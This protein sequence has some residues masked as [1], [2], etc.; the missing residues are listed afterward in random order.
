M[1]SRNNR[2]EGAAATGGPLLQGHCGWADLQKSRIGTLL[3]RVP[4][5]PQ[6]PVARR[7]ATYRGGVRAYGGDS[8][9]PPGIFLLFSML[10]E[11]FSFAK[12]Y[13]SIN[14]RLGL[15]LSGSTHF[16]RVS[17]L[18]RTLTG[19]RCRFLSSMKNLQL[20]FG[21]FLYCFSLK[22]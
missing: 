14:F 10:K 3:R 1:G 5:P 19:S 21:L 17:I 13:Y 16:L 22:K 9:S 12:M 4:I 20:P 11:S 6:R 18:D 15:F 2:Q 7:G 8:M